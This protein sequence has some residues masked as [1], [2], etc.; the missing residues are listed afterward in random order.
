MR[1]GRPATRNSRASSRQSQPPQNEQPLVD[2][3]G[4]SRRELCFPGHSSAESLGFDPP[5]LTIGAR[6]VHST[7][8]SPS[9]STVLNS[10]TPRNNDRKLHLRTACIAKGSEKLASIAD[11]RLQE[12]P[13][14]FPH[15]PYQMAHGSCSLPAMLSSKVFTALVF[16]N[17]TANPTRVKHSREYRPVGPLVSHQY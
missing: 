8:Y 1:T 16:R 9:A 2:A 12:K 11:S 3:S 10:G 17:I 4:S 15:R 14:G 6:F 7:V 5:Q 13:G